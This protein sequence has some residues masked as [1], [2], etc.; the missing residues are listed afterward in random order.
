MVRLLASALVSHFAGPGHCERHRLPSLRALPW[1]QDDSLPFER[2]MTGLSH[3][4]AGRSLGRLSSAGVVAGASSTTGKF[5][6][7]HFA[8]PPSSG[9]TRVIPRRLSRSATRALVA[10]L[11]QAQ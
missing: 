1:T 6:D 5:R 7:I 10:S 11:G 2:A 3:G 8:T 9:W 4:S